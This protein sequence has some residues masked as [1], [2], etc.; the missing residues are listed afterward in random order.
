[1]D[2]ILRSKEWNFTCALR[3]RRTFINCIYK[4]PTGDDVGSVMGQ[5]GVLG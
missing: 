2:V 5:L 1:M 3:W 4:L